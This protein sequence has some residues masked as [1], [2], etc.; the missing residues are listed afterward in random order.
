MKYIYSAGI[1]CYKENDESF[2]TNF[3]ID[4]DNIAELNC[5]ML[6]KYNKG[7]YDNITR[8][9]CQWM[10]Q[11]EM[12]V[13][14]LGSEMYIHDSGDIEREVL[15]SSNVNRWIIYQEYNEEITG[16]TSENISEYKCWVYTKI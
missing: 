9:M 10:Q 7:I 8:I 5:D 1:Q 13:I 2:I 4:T 12:Y 14:A 3:W 15:N 11:F 6:D 16:Y